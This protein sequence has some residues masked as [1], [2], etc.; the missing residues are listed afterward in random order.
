ML[1]QKGYVVMSDIANPRI[2]GLGNLPFFYRY[3]GSTEEEDGIPRELPFALCEDEETGLISQV[4]DDLTII[5]LE[6]AYIKGSE[7]SGTMNSD[8]IG[9]EYADDFL[10]FIDKTCGDIAGKKILEIGCGR[11]Y[12]LSRLKMLKADVTGI[13]PGAQ[14]KVNDFRFDIINDFFPTQLINGSY[15]IIIAYGVLEHMLDLPAFIT[16]VK[17]VLHESGKLLLAV[18]NCEPYLMVGDISCLLHEHWHYFTKCSLSMA[19]L[20]NGLCVNHMGGFGEGILYAEASIYQ[21]CKLSHY[22]QK[23]QNVDDKI[24]FIVNNLNSKGM[25]LGIYAPARMINMLFR[26]KIQEKI[27][28]R[29]F[30]DNTLLWGKYLPGCSVAIEPFLYE[31]Q[32]VMQTGIIIASRTF[33][34]RIYKKVASVVNKEFIWKWHDVFECNE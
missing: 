31:D 25:S 10:A 15:D 30:D 29:L 22:R 28:L 9:R 26:E 27:K 7:L 8:G 33:G 5:S 1:H 14:S 11:G 32:T 2:W 12:L 34:D 23:N 3:Q 19:L 24:D 16:E 13:E 21:H 4:K 20:N 17:K 6:K 18:P